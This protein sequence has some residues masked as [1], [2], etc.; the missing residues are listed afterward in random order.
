MSDYAPASVLRH[1]RPREADDIIVATR[2][3]RP[4]ED[5]SPT[6]IAMISQLRGERWELIQR[7]KMLE[8]EIASK[9]SIIA[10][11]SYDLR[12]A[13]AALQRASIDME[14]ARKTIAR[15]ND[16]IGRW[17]D[18]ETWLERQGADET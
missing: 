10:K 1:H 3:Y 17:H 18:G 15:L 8:N 14:L 9:D 16:T 13:H 6:D 11:Q 4:L 7:L 5:A 2:A 12:L